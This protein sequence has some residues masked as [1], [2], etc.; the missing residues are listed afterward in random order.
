VY[1][2]VV[3]ASLHDVGLEGLESGFLIHGEMSLD[4]AT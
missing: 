2:L 4:D 3:C 1:E